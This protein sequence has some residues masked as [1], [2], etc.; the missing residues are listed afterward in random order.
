MKWLLAPWL[1]GFL[2]AYRINT[3]VDPLSSIS[4]RNLCF[5]GHAATRGLSNTDY[6]PQNFK[7]TC[8]K[9]NGGEF[10]SWLRLLAAAED[11]R[12]PE[13]AYYLY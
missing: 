10:S 2:A 4:E 8:N 5:R 7:V 11:Y 12:H 13:Q 3:S 6:S 9:F 1:L